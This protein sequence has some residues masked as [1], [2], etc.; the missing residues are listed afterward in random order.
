M[1][2][3][4]EALLKA[5]EAKSVIDDPIIDQDVTLD[6]SPLTEGPGTTISDYKLL[7]QIGEGG[8]AVVYMAEQEKPIR[9][10]VALKIIKLGMDTKQVI[11]RFEAERQALAVMDHPNI[12]KVLNAGTTETGRPYFVMELVRGV[13]ISKYCDKNKL[14][15]KERLDLFVQVCNAVQH[16]HQKGIIHRDIK[17]SN[18]MVTLHD[19][20]PVPKIIDFGIAKAT[21]QRLTEKTLFT[22]YAQ[23][24]GTPAYMSPEQAEMSGLDIDTRTDIYSLGVLLYE[25][26]TG[27]TPFSEEQLRE[28]GYVEMQR[29]I[30]EEEPLKP[31]TRLSTFGDTLTDV[32]EH[33]KANPDLLRKLIRGDLDWIVMK[34]LEKDRTRRY[35]AVAELAADV[36]RHLSNEPV[37]AAAPS[38][39]YRLRK[40]IRRHRI[41]M[42][43][44]S[45]IAA[46]LLVGL[47]T[48]TVGFLQAKSQRERAFA[49]FQKARAAV[50]EMTWVAE[51]GLANTPGMEQV[52]REL[53]QKAQIFYEGFSKESMGDQAVHSETGRA[54]R[55]VGDI[56]NMLGQ[57][58]TA[59]QS[60]RKAIDIFEELAGKSPHVT[61]YRTELAISKNGLGIAL[62]ALGQHQE[63]G[64]AL[65]GVIAVLEP[66]TKDFPTDLNYLKVLADAYNSQG[67]LLADAGL[68]NKAEEAYRQAL[69]IR[70]RLVA[71]S[72][73]V[74]AYRQNLAGSYYKL[75]LVLGDDSYRGRIDRPQWPQQAEQAYRQALE[76]QRKLASDFPNVPGYKHQ[77]ARI[78]LSLGNLLMQTVRYQE[79]EEFFRQALAIEEKLVVDFPNVPGYRLILAE[80]NFSLSLM[81]Y[82]SGEYPEAEELCRQSIAHCEK[83]IADSPGIHAY[84]AGLAEKLSLLAES[85]TGIVDP[86][87][88]ERAVNH[89]KTAVA[90]SP[91]QSSYRRLLL[92]YLRRL[93][94]GVVRIQRWQEAEQVYRQAIAFLETLE[95]KVPVCRY[96]SAIVQNNLGNLLRDMGRD[97]EADEIFRQVETIRQELLIRFPNLPYEYR[98]N[99]LLLNEQIGGGAF[100]DYKVRITTV[101]D[102]Q[103]YVRCVGHDGASDS[104]YVWIEQ[105]SDGPRGSFADW[106]RYVVENDANFATNSWQGSAGFERTDSSLEHNIAAVWSI[107]SPGDYTIRFATRE[108]GA[109]LDSFV[110]QLLSLPPP[111]GDGPV[112][113]KVTE[114]KVFPE[115]DGRMVVEAEHFGSRTAWSC[116]WLMVPDETPGDVVHYKF[117][118]TGYLQ[119]LPDRTPTSRENF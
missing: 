48:A 72:P 17:P 75:G 31:S 35:N 117:R 76:L 77:L 106:Y 23:M 92:H 63:A 70:K 45:L 55:R 42:M 21:S 100:V 65:S 28:A 14:T 54:Y 18:V 36:E 101:G 98:K 84:H 11:A 53:L 87:L 64:G 95:A 3:D 39:S 61:E 25:L 15:T 97:E 29:I 32:A 99:Y 8:M 20:K 88:L 69:G 103:L 108:D 60:Y 47:S 43:A 40:F 22:R 56:H 112:E 62:Q 49:N 6:T 91:S 114:D 33:R 118:G 94:G 67:G 73:R 59:E 102:Y 109:A 86:N 85:P 52:R 7:E 104:V 89:L 81:L 24:I 5:H 1:R 119:A 90:L 78:H 41:S 74:A 46:A 80:S 107:S 12:A 2:A 4:V 58:E 68:L 82:A 96:E 71:E 105:L 38:V 110:F 26:L 30:R 37:E 27:V 10:R 57:Y 79:P 51:E 116:N 50:D 83:L 19:G 115:S 113:S 93:A 44:G 66:L 34:S 111:E 13:S 9:R 16:A